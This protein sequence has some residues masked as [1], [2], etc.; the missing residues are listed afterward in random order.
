MV[1]E[2]R[3]DRPTHACVL[4]FAVGADGRRTLLGGP[5][6]AEGMRSGVV[7]LEPGHA[8]GRH[9]TR[10]REELLVVLEGIG[11]LVVDGGDALPLEAGSGAYVPPQQ[12]HDVVN[13]GAGPLRYVYVVAPA[14]GGETER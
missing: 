11:E 3:A 7:L 8:V 10:A 2:M 5:G 4:R 1:S 9:S 12:E 6:P 14:S 13:T